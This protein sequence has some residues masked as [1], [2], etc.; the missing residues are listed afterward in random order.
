VN[1][2]ST[3]EIGEDGDALLVGELTFESVPAL[4]RE[5]ERLFKIARAVTR[6][7]LSK[8]TAADSAG[9]ALLLEW[10]AM[11]NAVSRKL[12]ISNAPPGLMSLAILCEADEVLNMSGRSLQ[13]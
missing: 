3:I 1:S 6:V 13:A 10:Q 11:Q 9:L 12:V 5:S 2:D 7:D 4:F 8:I